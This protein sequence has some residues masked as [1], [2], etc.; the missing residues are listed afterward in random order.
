MRSYDHST[1]APS[2]KWA[3]RGTLI[4]LALFAL[5]AHSIVHSGK[6]SAIGISPVAIAV[7]G[8]GNYTSSSA[9]T[10]TGGLANPHAV[11]TDS[12]G[13]LYVADTGNNRVLFFPAESTTAT[14]VY[15]QSNFSDNQANRGTDTPGA[16]R[17]YQP[18]GVILDSG[19]NL[20]VADTGNNRVL[21]FPSGQTTASSV[22]GQDDNFTDATANNGGISASS[23]SAPA[24]V[25]LDLNDN[26]YIADA[27]NN[28]TLYYPSGQ[29]TATRIY[30]QGGDFTDNMANNNGIGSA[31]LSAPAGVAL[32]AS[33]DI[34]SADA[35]N[36]RVL[37]YQNKLHVTSQPAATITVGDSF[38]SAFSL[39][40]VGSGL[41][42]A[43][44]AGSVSLLIKSG[45]GTQGATLG[46]TTT[47]TGASGTATFNNLLID[48][49]G[50]GYILTG[51]S[52]GVGQVD[53]NAFDAVG[54][55]SETLTSISSPSTTLNG[56]DKSMTW[57][58]VLDIID[59]RGTGAGW[60]LTITSTQ[61]KTLTGKTLPTTAT[62]ITALDATC[63][64]TAS[65]SSATN[66]V[67]YPLT[68]PA[69]SAAPTPVKFFN[70]ASGSGQGQFQLTITLS[71]KVPANSYKGTYTSTI[72]P[73]INDGA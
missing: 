66:T 37:H 27:G 24:E 63:A 41:A 33:G 68:V 3:R 44:F 29:T 4:V 49:A 5:M 35:A 23:L 21:Y 67:T 55:L 17:L 31:S 20:Y 13:D 8:Q 71:T 45:S 28:R 39:T 65:C 16:S 54:T 2:R 38:S 56:T 50:T 48:T 11:A 47:V 72:T 58:I 26:L 15:G 25:A 14:R 30:G 36:S 19:D 10:G 73:A 1:A 9:D 18:G 12:S 52:S 40:D 59:T 22:Y 51:K 42:F 32:D 53:T 43:D 61:L 70:A 64:P 7:Y 62:R 6:A 69:D 46:G 60:N 34:Y 57:Q